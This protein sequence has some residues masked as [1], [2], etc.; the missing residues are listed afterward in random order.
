MLSKDPDEADSCIPLTRLCLSLHFSKDLLP[1]PLVWNL[2]NVCD[3]VDLILLVD[4]ASLAPSVLIGV[5][6][7]QP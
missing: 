1:F 5:S 6:I 2:G 7:S 3:C 4:S